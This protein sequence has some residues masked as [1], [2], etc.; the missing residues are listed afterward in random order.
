MLKNSRSKIVWYRSSPTKRVLSVWRSVPSDW[1]L[2]PERSAV[3]P[4]GREQVAYYKEDEKGQILQEGTT[5]WAQVV[6]GWQRRP[7]TAPT[8]ADDPVLHLL[9]DVR[10]PAYWRLCWAAGDQQARGFL[11]G[12]TSVVPP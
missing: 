7:L 4:A 6:P 10:L 11:I 9:L 8:S 5:S 3:H 1:Y 12:G 2:Q